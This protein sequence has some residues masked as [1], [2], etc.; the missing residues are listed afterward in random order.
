MEIRWG[1]IREEKHMRTKSWRIQSVQTI[2]VC[3]I[4]FMLFNF[5]TTVS[6]NIFIPAVAEMK[7]MS[8][9]TL[10]HANTIGNLI[11]VIFALS[12]GVISKKFSLKTLT[13]LGLFIGGISYI[14]IPLV[15]AWM[16]GIFIATNYIATMFYA[17]IT[18]GARIGNWYPKRKGEILGIV[19]SVIIVS[20]LVWL[21]LFSKASS[22][23]GIAHAMMFV[24]ILVI[25]LA[26]AGIFVI[27]DT[28]ESVGLF[29]ENGNL[30]AETKVSVAAQTEWTYK[31]LLKK[32]RFV[33]FSVGWGLSMPGM[34][35]LSVAIIPIMVSK[36]LSSEQ[37]V[38]IATFAGGFQL[39][40]S[41]VSGFMDTRI[42]Q[43][44]VVTLFII[45][46]IGGLA[47]FGLA[48]KGWVAV[49][50]IGYYVVMFMMGAPNNLQ[51]SSYLTMAGGGGSIYMMFYSLATAIASIFLATA[52]SVLAFSTSRFGGNYTF[53]MIVFLV[54]SIVAVILLNTCGFKKIEK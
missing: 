41:I 52:S 18:V 15:P 28:P 50:V 45:L 26:V 1:V 49:M 33:L 21:P 14:L 19:T 46:E 32:P 12:V 23:F 40:G 17:Q 44:F 39:L 16:T 13:V 47:V 4:S 38:L 54:E 6:L 22:R 29:P 30:E 51:P 53:A 34:M 10:Y 27:H 48:P 3:M 35:G 42:G 2:I 31:E 8:S 9:S 24:G 5:L 11:S 7:G 20:S 43:R 37:A 25:L 36:G